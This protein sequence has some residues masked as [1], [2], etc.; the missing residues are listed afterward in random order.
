LFR[1]LDGGRLRQRGTFA[2]CLDVSGR[3]TG[4]F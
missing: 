2:S 4:R 1:Y 3:G